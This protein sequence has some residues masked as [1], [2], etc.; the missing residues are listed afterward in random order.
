MNHFH[1]DVLGGSVGLF[2]WRRNAFGIMDVHVEGWA[3]RGRE[4]VVVVVVVRWGV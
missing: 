4:V 1:L 2:G 3:T